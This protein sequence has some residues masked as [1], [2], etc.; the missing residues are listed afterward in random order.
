MYLCVLQST[1]L[2][3]FAIGKWARKCNDWTEGSKNKNKINTFIKAVALHTPLRVQN[4]CYFYIIL[5]SCI[6]PRDFCSSV[7]LPDEG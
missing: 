5:F 2:I 3:I 7:F 4:V 1:V 6:F